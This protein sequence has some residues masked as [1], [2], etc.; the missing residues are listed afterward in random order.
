MAV[1]QLKDG[2]WIVRYTKGTLPDDPE[3]TREYF[4]RGA[5]AEAAARKRNEELGFG[6]R[7]TK[8]KPTGP[9]FSE[10]AVSYMQDDR[11]NANSRK[12][13]GYRLSANILPFFGP[14]VAT[15]ITNE[16]MKRYVAMRRQAT[17]TVIDRSTVKTT[18]KWRSKH[19]GKRIQ[20]PIK[21][22]TIHRELT[23]VKAILNWAAGQDPPLISYNPVRDFKKPR[24]ERVDIRP[25][26]M[27]ETRAILKNAEPHLVR[28]IKLS[29]YLGVRPGAVELLGLTWDAVNWDTGTIEVI[30]AE[31][32]GMIRRHVP[33]HDGF[34]TELK[35]WW[36]ADNKTGPIIHYRKKPVGSI[37]TAWENTLIRAGIKRRLRPYD[38]R[39]N[40]IT[41]ALEEGA[42]IGAVAS[43]VGSSPETL[44]RHYQHVTN[45]LRRQT[46]ALIRPI[47]QK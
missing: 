4:G 31:K 5:A 37:K 21:D 20:V 27:A 41:A 8:K 42:D 26:S 17:R 18:K 3:R 9:F 13:L 1:H 39:H 7:R 15:G 45:R 16:D 33:I 46:V 22:A 36:K 24:P 47:E 32:G 30:S 19:E 25:P 11:F 14:L 43:I 35:T 44:R 23:D 6:R 40:F 28:F 29:Y 2:R 12:L 34:K 38:L 10:L